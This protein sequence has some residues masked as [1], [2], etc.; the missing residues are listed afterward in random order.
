MKGRPKK[1]STDTTTPDDFEHEP[2]S[3][4]LD[5]D[6]KNLFDDDDDDDEAYYEP[7]SFEY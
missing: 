4:D 5:L 1:V 2:T 3:N 6:I 7:Y